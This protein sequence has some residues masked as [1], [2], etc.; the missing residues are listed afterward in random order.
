MQ[1]TSY[2][3]QCKILDTGKNANT[4]YREKCKIP[5]TGNDAKYYL[6]V[7]MQNTSY[8]EQ[9]KHTSNRE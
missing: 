2:R 4:S 5:V 3:E 9:C 7:T 1:N 8:R 6:Q